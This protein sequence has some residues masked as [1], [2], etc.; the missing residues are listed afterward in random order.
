MKNALPAKNKL[1]FIDRSIEKLQGAREEMNAWNICNSMIIAWIFNSLDKTLHGSVAN[2]EYAKTCEMSSVIDT[3][4]A[5]LHKF[6]KS[7]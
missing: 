6:I 3:R 2:V 1:G 7:R 5:M 4:K